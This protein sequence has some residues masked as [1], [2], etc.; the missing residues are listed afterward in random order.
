VRAVQVK[1]GG[2]A[3]VVETPEPIPAV[4]EV[5]V[6]VAY[7]AVCATDRKLFTRELAE[8]RIPGHE[9]A[10]YLADG[11]AVG[12]H[13]DIGCGSCA[14]CES[15]FENRCPERVSIGLDRDG[16]FAEVV[17][18]PTDRVLPLRDIEVT[19]GPLIEP[20]ACCV[21]ATQTTGARDGDVAVVVGAGPMGILSMW[22]LQAHGARVGVCQRSVERRKLASE[23]GADAALGPEDDPTRALGAAPRVAVVTAPGSIALT[24]ALQRVEVGGVVHAFSGS[25]GGAPV[26]AN[27]VHYRH[28]RLVGSTGSSREDYMRALHLVA[29]GRVPLDSMPRRPVHLEQVPDE[30]RNSHPQALKTVVEVGGTRP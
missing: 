21:H 28:L 5:A 17:T 27:L 11:T 22:A 8:P 3:E 13:P 9:I 4:D 14:F 10:G 25:P 26:D 15:G 2:H 16:G 30:L 18:A 19:L 24:W 23:L 1:G 29:R 12:V 20:L 6:R 7:A